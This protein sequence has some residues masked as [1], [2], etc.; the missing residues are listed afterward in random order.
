MWNQ[1]QLALQQA[2]DSKDTILDRQFLSRSNYDQHYL[3]RTE[4]TQYFV[5]ISE[6]NTIERFEAERSSLDHLTAA[7][8]FVVP[9]SIVSGT[10]LDHAFHVMEWLNIDEPSKEQW[11]EI[12]VALARMH[13]KS[14][15]PLFG[16]DL[17]TYIG[18]TLQPNTWNKHWDIF[19]SE[20]RIAWQ[21]QL[22]HE[23]G[24]DLTD[25]DTF[26]ALTVKILHH[27]VSPALVHGDFWRGNIGVCDSMPC[28]YDAACYY[29]DPET[30]LAMSELFAKFPST[31]YQGYHSVLAPSPHYEAKKQLYQLYHL[32]N[33]ANMFAGNYL[34]DA[35]NLIIEIKQRYW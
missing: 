22:L 35:K 31:F 6:K 25:I 20:Q 17:D 5:K 3:I 30:D 8:T 12:G 7:S 15:Q 13:A 23:K 33:H 11:F 16:F 34:I 29:G 14:E 10:T 21:L 32:L 26:R 24:V 28:C 27:P 4:H 18:D 9:A 1:I 2:I 19:F